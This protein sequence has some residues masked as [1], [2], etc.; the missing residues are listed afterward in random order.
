[1]SGGIP[2]APQGRPDNTIAQMILQAGRDR[3][4]GLRR[5]SAITAN[6]LGSLGDIAQ[7]YY[8]QK[9]EEPFR[10]AQLANIQAQMEDRQAQARERDQKM[11]QEHQQGMTDTLASHALQ[12]YGAIQGKAPEEKDAIVNN[13]LSSLGK[14]GTIPPQLLQQFKDQYDAD[15]NG[16]DGMLAGLIKSSPTFGKIQQDDEEYKARI[17]ASRQAQV[18]ANESRVE[19]ARLAEEGRNERAKSDRELRADMARQANETKT[20]IAQFGAAGKTEQATNA[21]ES[22]VSAVLNGSTLST[23]PKSIQAKVAD[24]ARKQGG[25]NGTGF[26]PEN[27]KALERFNLFTT[28]YSQ[29]ER[30]D[31]LLKD[32]EVQAAI[33]GMGRGAIS[34]FTK[35]FPEGFGGASTKV[36]EAFDLMANFSDTE[37][38]KRSGAQISQ[39]EYERLRQF[40][41]SHT[42][43]ADSNLTNLRHMTGWLKDNMR[44]MGIRRLPNSATF[45]GEEEPL[46]IGT[47]VPAPV[48]SGRFTVEPIG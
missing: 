21:L 34:N 17:E 10:Q 27:Q 45:G 15:P 23:L 12:V 8:Q 26:V 30:L 31:T 39:Q 19:A 1:M 37:L 40:T 47:R 33:G 2:W 3:A 16:V 28:L 5:G 22:G 18:A 46:S 38:R 20:A 44:S 9:R 36:K 29:S 42:K 32:P 48:K 7:G 43:Q 4:E 14:N 35:E 6:A 13:Y 25:I 41:L 11:Q 24:E